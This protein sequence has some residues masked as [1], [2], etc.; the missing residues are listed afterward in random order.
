MRD[1]ARVI[2]QRELEREALSVTILAAPVKALFAEYRDKSPTTP[3]SCLSR[4][5]AKF[6]N[7]DRTS[8]KWMPA[9]T[10]IWAFY[11]L[12]REVVQQEPPSHFAI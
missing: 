4:R 6:Q 9:L 1:R 7:R 11:Q 2:A 12:V 3:S 10:A 8:L 5:H